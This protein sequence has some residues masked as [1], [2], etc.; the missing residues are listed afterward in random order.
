MQTDYDFWIVCFFWVAV[1]IL[2]VPK[3]RRPEAAAELTMK[4]PR[5]KALFPPPHKP[6]F[7]LEADSDMNEKVS[8]SNLQIIM[9]IDIWFH[10]WLLISRIA[11]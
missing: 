5:A 6:T 11:E 4:E 10:I 2:N 7:T 8:L 3:I 1:T 9:C